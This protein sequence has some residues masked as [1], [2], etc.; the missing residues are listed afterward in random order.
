MTALVVLFAVGQMLGALIGV[1]SAVWSELAYMRALRDGRIDKGEKE[2]FK[3]IGR[4][5]R[6]GMTIL[7][8]S[9]LGL[10]I[11]AYVLQST[12]PALT[13]SY[14]LLVLL[15][16]LIIGISW[17]F[18]REALPFAEGSIIV[19]SAWWFLFYLVSGQ[20]TLTSIGAAISFFILATVL[21]MVIVKGA[22]H[23]GSSA[24]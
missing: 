6:F 23:L 18:A 9:S 14:W 13:A 12:P 7:L 17:A 11:C 22:R 20:L 16:A 4:G 15:S 8:L 1:G 3:I 21:L 5:L 24:K 10:I 19:F 2:H